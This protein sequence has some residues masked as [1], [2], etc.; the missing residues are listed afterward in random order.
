MAKKAFV[1]CSCALACFLPQRVHA[2]RVLLLEELEESILIS[3]LVVVNKYCV[4]NEG[5]KG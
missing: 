1:C 2:D 3:F 5:K 4:R